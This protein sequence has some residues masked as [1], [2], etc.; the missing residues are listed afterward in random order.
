MGVAEVLVRSK[1]ALRGKVL[2]VFQPAEEGA[3]P[4]EVGGASEMIKAGILEKYKPKVAFAL[5]VWASV[6]VQI[7]STVST[8]PD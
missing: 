5:H 6:K 7:V 8:A 1:S 2:F 4:G 3:P